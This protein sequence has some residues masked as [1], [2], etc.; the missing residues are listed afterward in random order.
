VQQIFPPDA[1]VAAVGL[2]SKLINCCAACH[3]ESR[4][5]RDPFT[6]GIF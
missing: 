2:A 5:C 6:V 3:A 4:I 1:N